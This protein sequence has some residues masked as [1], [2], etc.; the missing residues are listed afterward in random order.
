MEKTEK[1]RTTLDQMPPASDP[2]SL[3]C[4]TCGAQGVYDVGGIF[5]DPKKVI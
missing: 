4:R 5:F 1:T 2:L 3:I